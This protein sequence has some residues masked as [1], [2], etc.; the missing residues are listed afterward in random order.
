MG[1]LRQQKVFAGRVTLGRSRDPVIDLA[2]FFCLI[3]VV[4]SHCMMVSPVLHPDGTVTTENTL[5]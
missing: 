1:F 5:M 3:L 2:R 4:L